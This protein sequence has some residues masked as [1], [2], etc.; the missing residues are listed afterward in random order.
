MTCSNTEVSWK[1]RLCLQLAAVAVVI[2]CG[3]A[4]SGWH[5]RVHLFWWW[6]AN[7]SGLPAIQA[8]PNHPM[9]PAPIP[10][11]WI[12]SCV[13]SL[14][15]SLPPELAA[16]RIVPNNEGAPVVFHD[17]SR[18]MIVGVPE[19]MTD[20]SQLLNRATRLSPRSQPFTLP[21]LRLALY[22]VSSDDFCWSMTSEELKWHVSRITTS[23]LIR[24]DSVEHTESFSRTGLDGLADF[25]GH[26][27]AFDWQSSDGLGGY[28]HFR[29]LGGKVEPDWIR[30]VCQSLNVLSDGETEDREVSTHTG[31]SQ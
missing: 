31:T 7:R 23:R 30:A 14:E 10:S 22:Q 8:I 13:G 20:L 27:V 17:E 15:L 29:D 16:N 5:Y 26:R 11:D 3:I 2:G 9:P 12:R 24:P 6:Q 19:D 4:V 21:R 28:I 18:V 1:Q 25:H